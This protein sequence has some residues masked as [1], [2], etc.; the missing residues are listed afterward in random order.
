M[1]DSPSLLGLE[2]LGYRLERQIGEG[3]MASVWLARHPALGKLAAVKVLDPL[4]TRNPSLVDRF[5]EEAR[6]Q[7]RLEHPNIVKVENVSTEPLAMVME[8]V[9]GSSLDASMGPRVGPVPVAS[10]LNLWRPILSAIEYAHARGVVHRDL[11]P[12]NILITRD[13]VPKVLDFGIAK[14]LAGHGRT[15]TGAWMGTP[16]YMA[17]EQIRSPK[18]VD[19]QAD[20][21]ALGVM[22]YEI[23]AGRRPFDTGEADDSDFDLMA[24]QVNEPP[25][26]PRRFSAG[27]PEAVATVILKALAKRPAERQQS[28]AELREELENAVGATTLPPPQPAPPTRY[29]AGPAPRRKRYWPWLLG[30]V[31]LA[32][33]LIIWA[34]WPPGTDRNRR[35]RRTDQRQPVEK[36]ASAR[37]QDPA[38]PDHPASDS[39]PPKSKPKPKPPVKPSASPPAKPVEVQQQGYRGPAATVTVW[40]SYLGAEGALLR[41]VIQAHAARGT[42]ITVKLRFVPFDAFND[43]MKI[44]APEGRGADL[45][46]FA[47]EAGGSWAEMGLLEPLNDHIESSDMARFLPAPMRV[48]VNRGV[49]YGLPMASKSVALIYNRA[50]VPTPPRTWDELLGICHQQRRAGRHGLI[51]PAAELYFHAPWLHGLGGRVLDGQGAP[52]I[53]TVP[54]RQAALLA[55]E[56]VTNC[57][58]VSAKAATL[59]EVFGAGKAAMIMSGPWER[60]NIPP[61]L[62]YGV[63]T[64][65]S[66]PNGAPAKPFA[67]VEAVYLNR[68]SANKAAALEIMRWLTSDQSATIR[69]DV[70]GQVVPNRAAWERHEKAPNAITNA[71]RSQ[72]EQSVPTPAAPVMQRVW[73]PYNEALLRVI[74]GDAGPEEAMAKAQSSVRGQKAPH[75]KE[76]DRRARALKKKKKRKKRKKRKLRK[77]RAAPRRK[78]KAVVPW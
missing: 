18:D 73:M 7:V 38:A 77:R 9:D 72:L 13:G 56:L 6:I 22:L 69:L 35:S 76:R 33:G 67:S 74:A 34:L 17:P 16:A 60:T 36:A 49:L 5:I 68:R 40:H 25:P 24:A 31:A 14:V 39:T 19:A 23:A 20:I 48:L 70:A 55:R 37:G 32:A 62:D 3:G 51:Y 43:K 12:A 52:T 78:G 64:L 65:P 54:A 15:R 46:I 75:F 27:I 21:Y 63:A 61:G 11:K 59:A 58:T 66:L 10:V 50:L 44:A 4:L 47:H 29:E 8:Y 42:P 2:V 57:G 26:D 30:G 41:K 71:F 1:T 45:V 53:D 28:V